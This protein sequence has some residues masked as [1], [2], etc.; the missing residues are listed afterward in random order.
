MGRVNQNI[1]SAEFMW[2]FVPRLVLHNRKRNCIAKKI[3]IE[4]NKKAGKFFPIF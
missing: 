3:L 1:N 4:D 2:I